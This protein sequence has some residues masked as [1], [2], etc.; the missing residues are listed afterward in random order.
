MTSTSYVA[1]ITGV[2]YRCLAST[3][4][5]RKSFY[6]EIDEPLGR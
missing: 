1:R 3:Y 4:F 6:W 5:L 2:T